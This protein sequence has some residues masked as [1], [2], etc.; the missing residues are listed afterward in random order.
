M[1]KIS[2]L[3]IFLAF[4]LAALFTINA[5]QVFAQIA[6]HVDKDAIG[7]EG[8]WFS[9]LADLRL[10]VNQQGIYQ[11]QNIGETELLVTSLTGVLIISLCLVGVVLLGLALF[12]IQRSKRRPAQ[13]PQPPKNLKTIE[14]PKKR[15]PPWVVWVGSA[16]VLICLVGT[17]I[18]VGF[19]LL[20][21]AGTT[22]LFG[23]V[24]MREDQTSTPDVAF[25]ATMLPTPT[26]PPT[27][28]E[29]P[30]LPPT[31]TLTPSPTPDFDATATFE[32]TIAQQEEIQPTM[33]ATTED[34]VDQDLSFDDWL[35]DVNILV[36]EDMW[37]SNQELIV[38]SAIDG[39]RLRGN[40]TFVQNAIGDLIAHMES[41]TTWDLVIF[42]LESRSFTYSG[43][44]FDLLSD[45]LDSGASAIIE[46]WYLD[47][48]A[49]GRIRPLMQECGIT[50]QEN[51][52]R[53][54]NEDWNRFVVYIWEPDA[55]VLS[56]PN[57]ITFLGPSGTIWNTGDV[58][59]V[60]RLTPN[61][62]A[63]LLAGLLPNPSE[64]FG[65]IA[66]CFDGRLIW[67]T[68]S[69]HN[70]RQSQM[71]PLWQNYIINALWARYAYLQQE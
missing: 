30:P 70:Y 54:E 26:D 33:T 61:S 63:R 34:A 14:Q 40:T 55:P 22:N 12:F 43:D 31:P 66:D 6:N 56:E 58:G 2:K 47:Q 24:G 65:L 48:I 59:D 19:G 29:T 49:S 57:E 23:M 35:R 16:V 42:A 39:L 28:T 41:A 5:S 18:V 32:S 15:L 45:Q 36:H 27:A 9:R 46:I 60:I 4:L 37:G 64:R 7:V 20:T 21:T 8:G 11:L 62:E 68:F 3:K 71:V 44:I 13:H 10:V 1:N 17:V 67:Q 38:S 25:T 51:W 50:F 53:Q 69:T 52:I